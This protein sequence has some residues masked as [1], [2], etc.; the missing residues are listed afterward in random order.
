MSVPKMTLGTSELGPIRLETDPC[1]ALT[2]T[3]RF[4]GRRS[5]ELFDLDLTNTNGK[6]CQAEVYWR[7]KICFM[8]EDDWD[9][10][11]EESISADD[12]K[13]QR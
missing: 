4:F 8:I 6:L 5:L 3:D 12:I 10:Y 13:V 1:A 2:T 11:E 7:F 9:D